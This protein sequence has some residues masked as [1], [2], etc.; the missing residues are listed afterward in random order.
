MN[1]LFRLPSLY[2][3]SVSIG[4]LQYI[5]SIVLVFSFFVCLFRFLWVVTVSP[6]SM[7]WRTLTVLRSTSHLVGCI[8]INICHVFL[9]LSWCNEFYRV[10]AHRKK[11][12]A[13]YS[14]QVKGRVFV[15]LH[16]DHVVF[17]SFLHCS[18]TLP[19]PRTFSSLYLGRKFFYAAQT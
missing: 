19:I 8:S 2:L 13:F 9:I 10:E 14:L 4:A 17:V 16:L 6:A 7:L 15:E 5:H 1:N 11:K 3:M 12:V 18:L